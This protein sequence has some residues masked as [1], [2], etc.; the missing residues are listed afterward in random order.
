MTTIRLLD[1]LGREISDRIADSAEDLRRRAAV[2]SFANCF[3]A[4]AVFA[5]FAYLDWAIKKEIAEKQWLQ[6]PGEADFSWGT[7]LVL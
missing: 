6:L 1:A 2:S 3:F 7:L 5:F 4:D